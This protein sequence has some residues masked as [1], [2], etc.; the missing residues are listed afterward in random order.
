[1]DVAEKSRIVTGVVQTKRG[2][3]GGTRSIK[4]VK[5]ETASIILSTLSIVFTMFGVL[6][7]SEP[8]QTTEPT[9]EYS[10]TYGYWYAD[11]GMTKLRMAL[12]NVDVEYSVMDSHI[13]EE[14]SEEMNCLMYATVPIGRYYITAYNHEETG[15][16]ITA[17]GKTCHQGTVSTCAADPRYH[18][19][20]EYLEIDGKLYVV[21]DTGS[22][23]KRRHIDLYFASYKD[24]AKYGSNYQTIYQVEFPFGKPKY[25]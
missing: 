1:M 20:G 6:L 11:L 15:G 8:K 22:A 14:P 21:E 16:K 25:D 10:T 24:M 13:E 2:V 23:V 19:F 3:N 18:K 5:T 9:V 4:K 12:Y 17:S 7:M